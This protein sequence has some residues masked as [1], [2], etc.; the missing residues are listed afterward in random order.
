M[1]RSQREEIEK[2]IS[3]MK[4]LSDNLTVKTSLWEKNLWIL[5]S[6]NLSRERDDLKTSHS[7]LKDAVHNLT[8]KTSH[9]EEV[10]DI[11][12]ALKDNLTSLRGELLPLPGKCSCNKVSTHR[13]Y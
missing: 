10:K 13:Y 4:S 2:V 3:E 6:S 5:I 11:L 8:Q 7:E 12:A 1:E 9:L